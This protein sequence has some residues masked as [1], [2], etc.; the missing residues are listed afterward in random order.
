MISPTHLSRT[1]PPRYMV[2]NA[3]GPASLA[4]GLAI[5][6]RRRIVL[7]LDRIIHL[8]V[9]SMLFVSCAVAAPTA[10]RR[11]AVLPLAVFYEVGG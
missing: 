10:A 5:T 9:A 6:R 1:G 8:L 3:A 11:D 7:R 4:L 2:A